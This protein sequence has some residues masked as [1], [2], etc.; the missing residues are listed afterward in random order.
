MY[1]RLAFSVAAHLEPEVLLVDEVLAVGD[2]AFQKKC[3]GKMGSVATEGR[4]VLFVS[5]NMDAIRRLCS[6]SILLR[7]GHVV[8]YGNTHSILHEYLASTV[9]QVTPD[10]WISIEGRRQG[11]GEACFAGV[12]FTSDNSQLNLHAYTGGPLEFSLTIESKVNVGV[13]SLAITIYNQSGVLLVNADILS[14]GERVNLYKG[15]NSLKLRIDQLH[16][17]HGVYTVGLWLSK[18]GTGCSGSLL[19]HVE[20]AFQIEVVNTVC[21]TFG[22]DVAGPVACSFSI[23][24]S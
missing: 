9:H 21:G 20:S 3:L 14:L 8:S 22:Q 15:C 1:M 18:D 19:D 5:H 24:E 6:V 2:A 16:L 17:S 4:T 23:L 7:H 12:S 13:G 11:T 10:S